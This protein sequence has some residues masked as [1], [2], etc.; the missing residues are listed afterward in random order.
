MALKDLQ[1]W[2]GCSLR[3]LPCLVNFLWG[4]YNADAC[5]SIC[6]LLASMCRLR[7]FSAMEQRR[8]F[9]RPGVSFL[10]LKIV[11]PDIGTEASRRHG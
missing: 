8:V 10:R 6:C 5:V 11:G 9:D 7:P 4:C 2:D 1:R 3:R